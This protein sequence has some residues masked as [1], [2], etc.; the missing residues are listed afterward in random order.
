[1]DCVAGDLV[2]VGRCLDEYWCLK[3]LMAPGC[4]PEFVGR[5]MAAVRPHALGICMAGAGGGGFMYVLARDVEA[6]TNICNIINN[7]Q[8]LDWFGSLQQ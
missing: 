7:M 3:K 5:L 1:M 2:G 8:V 4:E 6:R